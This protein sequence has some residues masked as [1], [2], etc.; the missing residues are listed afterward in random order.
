[1]MLACKQFGESESRRNPA[2][3][4]FTIA[5]GLP[6]GLADGGTSGDRKEGDSVCK[7]VSLIPRI[8]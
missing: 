3:I 8:K 6:A 1:M 4:A 7:V 5:F 2:G